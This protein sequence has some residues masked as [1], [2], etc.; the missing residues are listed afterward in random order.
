[1]VAD[2]SMA[3]RLCL[4]HAD[5]L[6]GVPAGGRGSSTNR[7]DH[8]ELSVDQGRDGPSRKQFAIRMKLLFKYYSCC[9]QHPL[10]IPPRKKVIGMKRIDN[11]IPGLLA[12]IDR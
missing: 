6:V 3:A 1:M 7:A 2:R 5:R 11:T 4:S 8:G 10:R 12:G 9:R